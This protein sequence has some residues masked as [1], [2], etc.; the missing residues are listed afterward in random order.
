MSEIWKSKDGKRRFRIPDGAEL[1][2]GPFSIIDSEGQYQ[3]NVLEENIL[4]FEIEPEETLD[5]IIGDVG[6]AF[7]ELFQ[8]LTNI[9][10]EDSEESSEES[11][12]EFE[13]FSQHNNSD[14][15]KDS[16]ASSDP[17]E[18]IREGLEN[19]VQGLVSGLKDLGK[20]L[21]DVLGTPENRQSLAEL[22]KFLQDWAKAD[23]EKEAQEAQEAKEAQEAQEASVDSSS[24]DFDKEGKENTENTSPKVVVDLEKEQEE[25]TVEKIEPK[26]IDIDDIEDSSEDDSYTMDDDFEDTVVRIVDFHDEVHSSQ[27]IQFQDSTVPRV[28]EDESGKESGKEEEKFSNQTEVTAEQEAVIDSSQQEKSQQ[29]KS[30]QEDLQKL[31]KKKLLELAKEKGVDCKNSWKKAKIIETLKDSE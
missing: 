28:D 15:R 1:Y 16:N 20:E 3:M 31:T 4:P 26:D 23:A 22:G 30:Q 18:D 8:D 10:D 13:P 9:F 29:E 14:E 7:S 2:Q 6:K 5:E 11:N 21:V 27:D 25:N 12:E 24:D 19:E 17:F